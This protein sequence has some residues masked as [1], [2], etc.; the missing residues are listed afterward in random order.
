MKYL[1]EQVQDTKWKNVIMSEGYSSSENLP[2]QYRIKNKVL[3]LQGVIITE[4]TFPTS[5]TE[6]F[7]IPN[8]K[9][10][11]VCFLHTEISGSEYS[12]TQAGGQASAYINNIGEIY[13]TNAKDIGVI[14]ARI[15]GEVPLD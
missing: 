1:K 11:R 7:K 13:L 2:M 12:I 3:Y 10:S 6:V 14:Y 4:D 9:L 15:W 8:L 5:N